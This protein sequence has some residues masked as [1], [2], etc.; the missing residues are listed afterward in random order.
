MA[1]IVGRL[2]SEA[3]APR[4]LKQSAG[5]TTTMWLAL[6]SETW[7]DLELGDYAERY[8]VDQF[9]SIKNVGE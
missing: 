4:I 9:S 7:T 8:L 5:F 2:P 3:D 1:R 6:S